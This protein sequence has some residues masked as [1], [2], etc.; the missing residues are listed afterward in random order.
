[1]GGAPVPRQGPL[2][3]PCERSLWGSGS[4]QDIFESA[5]SWLLPAV[6]C[7]QDLAILDQL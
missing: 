4:I 7:T 5:G 1:M 6:R 2:A 3:L